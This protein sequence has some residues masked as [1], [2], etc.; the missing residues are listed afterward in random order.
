MVGA[1]RKRLFR[2]ARARTATAMPSSTSGRAPKNVGMLPVRRRRE[3]GPATGRKRRG[4]GTSLSGTRRMARDVG[5]GEGLDEGSMDPRPAVRGATRPGSEDPLAW[6][7]RT[8]W[9][10]DEPSDGRAA[11]GR[12]AGRCAATARVASRTFRTGAGTG[13]WSG[14]SAAGI[15]GP[16]P[17]TESDCADAS[18]GCAAT[19]G[20]VEG[21]AG[22]VAVATVA[23]GG[24]GAGGG[25]AG[26]AGSS[27]SG[28]T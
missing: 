1:E 6:R 12:S 27:E 8:R 20:W 3:A 2:R 22:V 18:S 5:C 10:S 15:G 21:A 7:I 23:G 17:G 25:T 24:E 14:G 19:S 28:S 4:R 9:R 16:S 13:A 26:R 11:V